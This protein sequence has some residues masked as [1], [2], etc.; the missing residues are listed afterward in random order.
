MQFRYNP[1]VL[2]INNNA[3]RDVIMHLLRQR[4]SV[5]V[6]AASQFDRY[7]SSLILIGLK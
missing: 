7:L 6:K 1:S 2:E 3:F 4:D 5:L